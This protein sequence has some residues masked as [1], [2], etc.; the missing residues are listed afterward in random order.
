MSYAIHP[1]GPAKAAVERL[2]RNYRPETGGY[3]FHDNSTAAYQPRRSLRGTVDVKRGIALLQLLDAAGEP[4]REPA[5][6]LDRRAVSAS[7]D[8]ALIVFVGALAC[9]IKHFQI[10][11]GIVPPTTPFMELWSSLPTHTPTT[12]ESLKPM[13]HASR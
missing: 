5:P 7:P 6:R 12:K 2:S 10:I 11:A 9:S 4:R 13:N 3:T 1:T 8:S